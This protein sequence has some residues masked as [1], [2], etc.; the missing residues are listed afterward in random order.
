MKLIFSSYSG[1]V[2][3]ASIKEVQLICLTW[4]VLYHTFFKAL[5]IF[6]AKIIFPVLLQCSLSLARQDDFILLLFTNKSFYFYNKILTGYW[7]TPFH[8]RASV[9]SATVREASAIAT[10]SKNLFLV[11]GMTPNCANTMSEHGQKLWR[12]PPEN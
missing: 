6:L 7:W 2:L 3:D 8:R 10:I 1:L 4:L 12:N 9:L 11:F 5:K